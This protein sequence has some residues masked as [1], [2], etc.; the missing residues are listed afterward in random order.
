M[1]IVAMI[2]MERL[3]NV[4]VDLKILMVGGKPLKESI[5]S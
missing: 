5:M 3:N 4:D 1:M 2:L